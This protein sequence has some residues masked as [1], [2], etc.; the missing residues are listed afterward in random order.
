MSF[1]MSAVKAGAVAVPT[2]VTYEALAEDGPSLGL[3]PDS[4]AKIQD[5]RAAG[6]ESLSILQQAGVTMAFGTDLLGETHVR[7]N[8]E[9]AIR[10]RV[11]PSAGIIASATT[12]A[13][14]LVGMEGRLGVIAPGAIADLLV[15]QGSPME[16]AAILADHENNILPVMKAGKVHR[17]SDV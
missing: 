16:N 6:M 15:V 14:R 3:P 7:Q 11:L 12:I 17:R 4:I 2:L 1:A 13:A 10:A 5:V 8:E 9:F